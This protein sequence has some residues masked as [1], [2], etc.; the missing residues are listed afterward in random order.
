M[1]S[2]SY[3]FQVLSDVFGAPVYTQEVANSASLG[4]AFLAMHAVN[5]S[6]DYIAFQERLKDGPKFEL[7][8]MP[9][10]NTDKVSFIH[11]PVI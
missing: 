4:A 9:Q 5:L 8:A 6:T 2:M 7:V 3:F 1:C 10:P 11:T